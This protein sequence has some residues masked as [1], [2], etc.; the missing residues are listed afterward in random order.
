MITR[1]GALPV[2]MNPPIPALSPVSVR[3]RVARFTACVGGA[4]DNGK[5]KFNDV[6]NPEI[7]ALTFSATLATSPSEVTT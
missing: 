5:Y 6:I 4:T 3:I 7:R 2:M 1:F